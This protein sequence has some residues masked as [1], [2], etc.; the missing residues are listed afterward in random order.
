M[1]IPPWVQA[2][3]LLAIGVGCLVIADQA[4][5]SVTGYQTPYAI[6]AELPAGEPSTERLMLIVLDGVRVDA[7]RGMPHLQKLAARGSSG[8]VRVG[9]PSLSNP[10]RATTATGAWPEVHGVTNN[11]R[12][13]PPPMDS[14]FSLAKRQGIPRT[15]YGSDFW[16]RAFG[17]HLDAESAFTFDKDLHASEG[18]EPLI[19]R[20][21][22]VC[23]DMAAQLRRFPAGLIVVGI[24]ATDTAG[25][26]FGGESDEYLQV[27]AEADRCIAQLDD[28]RTTFV[29]TS[30]HGHIH[31]HGQGGHGGAEPVVAY[32]PLVLAGP[33]VLQSSG[34]NGRQVDIAPTICAL[35]GLPLP[36]NSQGRVLT[37]AITAGIEL[38][39]RQEGQQALMNARMRKRDDLSA[40]EYEIRFPF[41]VTTAAALLLLAGYLLRL[42]RLRLVAAALVWCA[43]YAGMFWAF[44]LGYSLSAVVREEYLNSFFLR[45]MTAAAAGLL[46]VAWS[47]RGRPTALHVGYFVVCLLALRV[48]WIHLE[49]GLIMREFMPDLG[50]AFMAYLDLLA[51]FGVAVGTAIALLVARLR[52]A[53]P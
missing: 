40:L 6:E 30:D 35:L 31:R 9:M 33:G 10:G 12:Y 36:A 17:E 26:D 3:A 41:A 49:H 5:K 2:L 38:Q 20:Q 52:T 14:I 25:H 18:P 39:D 43:L 15:V 48:T 42:G 53:S 7:S 22:E 28:E 1:R 16:T 8:I 34:W 47:F 45:N 29:V 32:V 11:G 4:W 13:R 50:R 27:V 37:E 51:I 21:R 19:D 23:A 24:T 44:G 46:V